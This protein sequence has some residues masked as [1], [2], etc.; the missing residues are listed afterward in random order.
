M[1]KEKRIF[2]LE[3]RLI[4]FVVIIIEIAE[5]LNNTRVGNHLAGQLAKSGT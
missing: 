5:S 2:D 4:D 3:E 1:M